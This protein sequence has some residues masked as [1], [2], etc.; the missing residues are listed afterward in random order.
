MF[1]MMK[2]MGKVK[3]VQDKMKEAQNQLNDIIVE[4]EA[5]AGMV[6]AKVNG[7]KQVVDLVIDSSLF[8]ED[9]QDLLK[10][11]IVGAINKGIAEAEEKGKE[12]IRKATEGLMPN[13]PGFDL[14]NM[15]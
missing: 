6:V 1:D 14:S 3:E 5:G 10:D 13:I 9:D 4:A 7:N 12:H 11:L 8:K 2:M 15:A